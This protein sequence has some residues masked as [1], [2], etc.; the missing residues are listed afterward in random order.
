MS[1]YESRDVLSVFVGSTFEDLQKYRS[2]VW[3]AL[4]RLDA[5]V[6]GMEYFGSRPGRP[7]DECL[8]AVRACRVYIGI[9]GMRYGSV[10]NGDGR[11][12]T[13]LEYDE[14]QRCSLPS[15]IYILD[16]KTQPVLAAHVEQGPG[17]GKLAGLKESL[18][19]RHVCSTFTTPDDLAAKVTRDLISLVHRSET[20]E[21]EIDEAGVAQDRNSELSGP[22]AISDTHV[23]VSTVA[24][25]LVTFPDELRRFMRAV[26]P[27][28]WSG[29]DTGTR[30]F[31]TTLGTKLEPIVQI[32]PATPS[33]LVLGFEMLA[34]GAL[35]ENFDQVCDAL[36]DL[37]P[38]MVRLQLMLASLKTASLLSSVASREGNTGARHLMFTVNLDPE[39]LDSPHLEELL[40]RYADL[41]EHNVVFEINERITTNYTTRLKDLQVDFDLRYCADDVNSWS[42]AAKSALLERVELSKVDYS[43]F[44]AAMQQRGDSA[45]RAIESIAAHR[46]AG[47]PLIVEGIANKS[48]LR[49]LTR[50]W[51][52]TTHGTLFGQ[53]YDLSP[54]RPWDAWTMDLR[55]FGLA[56]GHLLREKRSQRRRW[57][58]R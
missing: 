16:D 54:G 42:A 13:H 23:P 27:D 1:L 51:S 25:P 41:W 12:M 29:L 36:S 44:Q 28:L 10:P 17:A 11:S 55:T 32:I 35:G 46:I 50:H 57:A 6:R 2:A 3:D 47:K 9:F 43:T 58:Q 22:T 21:S 33:P 39:T 56:G 5:Q 18:K 48:Y 7:I 19:E 52:V 45:E 49:F 40:D 14:A 31:I 30:R 38:G 15:L 24:L 34:L 8:A 26:E 53:G 37:E 4:A 20:P